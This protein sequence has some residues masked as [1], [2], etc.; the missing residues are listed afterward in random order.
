[1]FQ[2]ILG[3]NER[4]K[5][6]RIWKWR[7]GS[8]KLSMQPQ[9][10]DYLEIEHCIC[11]RMHSLLIG[12]TRF[13]PK[14]A[15][16]RDISSRRVENEGKIFTGSSLP[17]SRLARWRPSSIGERS[18]LINAGNCWMFQRWRRGKAQISSDPH[19]S[20]PSAAWQSFTL[21]LTLTRA[22]A[23]EMPERLILPGPTRGLWPEGNRDRGEP[24]SDK[25]L[26]R[27]NRPWYPLS[28]PSRTTPLS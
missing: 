17:L 23:S 12:R 10:L 26:L 9:A 7:H 15:V 16:S 14:N 13:P 5:S 24:E 18:R 2:F 8:T 27:R 25:G 21:T 22:Y 20:P 19:T 28:I 6:P 1:M 4:L 3:K 11:P